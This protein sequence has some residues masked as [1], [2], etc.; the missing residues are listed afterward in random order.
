MVERME[1][2]KK[3]RSCVIGA[4]SALEYQD[5]L[6]GAMLACNPVRIGALALMAV[7]RLRKIGG[8]YAY[9]FRDDEMKNKK[10]YAVHFRRR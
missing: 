10:A 8:R 3:R 4:H 2:A 9:G 1:K 7:S 6:Q 5:G